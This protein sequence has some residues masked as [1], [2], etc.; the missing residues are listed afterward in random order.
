MITINV[1]LKVD[2]TVSLVPLANLP[3]AT[4]KKKPSTSDKSAFLLLLAL[5]LLGSAV[6]L[7]SRK[8]GLEKILIIF[9]PWLEVGLDVDLFATIT[10]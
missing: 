7:T 2:T 10:N 3:L 1:R 4:L 9:F 6:L 5:D 8:L